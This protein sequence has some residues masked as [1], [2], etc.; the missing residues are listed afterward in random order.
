MDDK[1]QNVRSSRTLQPRSGRLGSRTPA[2]RCD[3]GGARAGASPPQ[4]AG[5]R[6]GAAHGPGDSR[7]DLFDLALTQSE[8]P[9]LFLDMIA[10]V[11]MARDKRTYRFFQDSRGGRVLI[12][13]SQSV[14]TIVTAVADYVARRLVERE[15]AVTVGLARGRGAATA[16]RRSERAGDLAD[17]QAARER[18]AFSALRGRAIR[19]SSPNR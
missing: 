2:R 7:A 11:D 10:F 12:A 9:R 4:G 5:N 19:L 15:R 6:A 1:R 13:E 14:D 3:R 16:T 18:F 8:H 17:R